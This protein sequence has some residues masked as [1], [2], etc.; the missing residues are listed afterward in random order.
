MQNLVS[1]IILDF[2]K[3]PKVV[4][5]VESVLWQNTDFG[6][7]IVVVDNSVN[8]EN[9][10]VLKKLECHKNVTVVINEKNEGYTRGNNR[11]VLLAKGEYIA[12]V[13]PD[14]IWK[15]KDTLQKLINYLGAH[16]EVGI[17]GPKQINPDG[18]VAMSV[19]AFPNLFVQIAR[20]T[21]LRHL[22]G[23]KEW[24]AYDEMQHLDYE[25]VQKV[26]WLQSSF[27]VMRKDDWNGCGGFDE[28]YFLFMSDA[29][30]CRKFWKKGK[31]VVY[32]PEVWV[33]ADGIRCSEGGFSD[34][35]KQWVLRQHFKDSLKYT[36]KHLFERNP[37]GDSNK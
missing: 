12:I 19:R 28:D 17:V 22:P 35:C 14:I 13:N 29:E 20:R 18:C 11:G 6:V 1:I 37:R 33:Y 31:A 30:I 25:K 34:F 16:P 27:M 24:V 8:S 23:I 15:Q 26:D 32:F 36:I 3:A 7:E 2:L 4:Q 21:F 5:N 9:A 10:K